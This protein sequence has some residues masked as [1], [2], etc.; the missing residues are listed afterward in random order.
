MPIAPQN[1]SKYNIRGKSLNFMLKNIGIKARLLPVSLL[2]LI[3]TSACKQ[4]PL[5]LRIAAT[6]DVHGMIYPYDFIHRKPADHS[7]AHVYSYVSEQQGKEDTLFFLL[8]NGD[9]LQGQPTVYYYNFVDTLSEHLSARVMNFMGYDAGSVGNHDIEAGP[10]VYTRI[11]NSFKFPWLAANAVHSSTGLPYFEPYTILKAGRKKIAIL[12]LITPGIPQWLPKNLWP[13]MEFRDMLA[14]ASEWVPRIMEEEKPDLM[15]G[16]F[17]SGTDASYGGNP[18][19]FLNENAVMLVAEQVP[20][21]HIIF[22]GHDHRVSCQKVIN[23]EGDS[24]LVIDPGSHGRFAGEATVKFGAGGT[25]ISGKNIPMSEYDPSET[26]MKEFAPEFEIVSAYLEDTITWLS[27]EMRGLDALFGP[28][29]MM[30]L[31]HELQLEM[32][33]AQISFTA[34]LSITA[35]LNEGPLLVSDLFKL[36]RYENML[37]RME[38]S[39]A[40]IDGFLE[41]AVGS[42]YNTM[43]GPRDHLLNFSSDR[44]GRLAAPYYNFSSA[45]GINYTVDVR[46]APGNRVNIETLSDGSPFMESNTYSVALNSYRG[47]GGGGHLTAGAGIPKE[48]L[49]GRISWSTD[50]D[51]RYYL[52]EYLGKQDTLKPKINLN[53]SCIPPQLVEPAS[54]IDRKVLD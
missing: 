30:T 24:V 29:S 31:I 11:E 6:T 18:D 50:R 2:I 49:S 23:S 5:T 1:V 41:H 20:G 44:P 3:C 9:F 34:P 43:S 35:A 32:S 10:Q 21:F 8:D 12:G 16:L 54:I 38:L 26:L 36:Y 37:Y 39:G 19:P 13:D 7:L 47:N 52:M 46:R 25:S 45:A 27:E 15:V 51:L 48:D 40:E 4:E 22:A 14:T 53:W 33:G 42:W 28:S 17:H